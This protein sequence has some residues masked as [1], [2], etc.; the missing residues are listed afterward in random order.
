MVPFYG[1]TQ[2]LFIFS[3]ERQKGSCI[4]LSENVSMVNHGCFSL[5]RYDQTQPHLLCVLPLIQF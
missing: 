4:M 1:Q 2:I 3:P 5:P